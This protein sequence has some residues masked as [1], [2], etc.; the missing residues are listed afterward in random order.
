MALRI[1][2]YKED[3]GRI[4]RGTAFWLLVLLA[5]YGAATLYAFLSWDWARKDLGFTVPVL[6]LP[7]DGRLA[8]SVAVFL[9]SFLVIRKAINHP[10]LAD[11]LIDTEGELKRVTW[12]S[13]PE[14]WNGS[15]VVVVTVVTMLVLLAG[16]DIIL[17]RFFETV[18][19]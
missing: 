12:P 1:I 16:A 17:S 10:K 3:Q 15:L 18:V 5:Y 6:E 9:V 11:L 19:F 14:T 13:W 8:V 2:E 4:T 7:F